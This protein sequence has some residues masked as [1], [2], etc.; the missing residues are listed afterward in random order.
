MR[1][2]KYLHLEQD[3]YGAGNMPFQM[4]SSPFEGSN[5]QLILKL[6]LLILQISNTNYRF[7]T[8]LPQLLLLQSSILSKFKYNT[9]TKFLNLGKRIY[10]FYNE[11]IL[12]GLYRLKM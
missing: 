6:L 11:R 3:H 9:S 1:F 2:G 5:F 4:Q 10:N 7:Q 12:F 8:F